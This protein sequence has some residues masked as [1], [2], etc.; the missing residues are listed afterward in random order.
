MGDSF[1]ALFDFGPTF[2]KPMPV[3]DQRIR[4][5]E[6]PTASANSR[7][8]IVVLKR[9]DLRSFTLLETRKRGPST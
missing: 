5:A 6:S 3:T 2:S 9:Q 8:F 1:E 7:G 4:R